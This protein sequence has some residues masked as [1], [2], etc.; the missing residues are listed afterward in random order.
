MPMPG[1]SLARKKPGMEDQ[2]QQVRP[3]PSI[4]SLPI[5]S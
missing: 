4:L 2:V 3:S 1:F 5:L